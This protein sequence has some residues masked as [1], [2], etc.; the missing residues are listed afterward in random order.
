MTLPLPDPPVDFDDDEIEAIA[1]G[2]AEVRA[3]GDRRLAAAAA[4]VLAKIAELLPDD[5]KE[6]LFEAIGEAYEPLGRSGPI[7]DTDLIR[8]A[9]ISE[10][11]LDISYGDIS[12]EVTRRRVLPLAIGQTSRSSMLL[13]W[14]CLR[15]GFRMFRLDRII[16]LSLTGSS[17]HPR[18]PELLRDCLARLE[19]EA[20][21]GGMVVTVDHSAFP[22]APKSETSE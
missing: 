15:N 17:F 16:T 22:V 2:M 12:D 9:C 21:K 3:I 14:C 20:K 13:A 4:S 5:G 7:A 6:L 18:R 11:A 19:A 10:E 1:F 8:A